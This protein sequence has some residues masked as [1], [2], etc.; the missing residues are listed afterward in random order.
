MIEMSTKGLSER[1]GWT[2]KTEAVS[3]FMVNRDELNCLMFRGGSRMIAHSL[4]ERLVYE[5]YRFYIYDGTYYEE[6]WRGGPRRN[7]KYRGSWH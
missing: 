5:T 6:I 7:A 4:A 3:P 1:Q 2:P